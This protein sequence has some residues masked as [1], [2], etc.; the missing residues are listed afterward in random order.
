MR[1]HAFQH[2]SL[3]A[4]HI[5][6]W[7]MLYRIV[8]HRP[9]YGRRDPLRKRSSELP[10]QPT[11][12]MDS[13]VDGRLLSRILEDP[14]IGRRAAA[15][16]LFVPTKP[17]RKPTRQHLSKRGTRFSWRT[18]GERVIDRHELV[19]RLADL[20]SNARGMMQVG[21]RLPSDLQ[22]FS[23]APFVHRLFLC[24][25]LLLWKSGCLAFP[26]ILQLQCHLV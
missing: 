18:L 1:V 2:I 22:R 6:D 9:A 16:Q 11:W 26:E 13:P 20:F 3:Q 21:C 10:H 23:I 17:S 24:R 8:W 25:P 7:A 15:F 19:Q 5:V 12:D 4:G 14:D